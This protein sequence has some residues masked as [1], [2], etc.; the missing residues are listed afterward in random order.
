VNWRQVEG[1]LAWRFTRYLKHQDDCLTREMGAREAKQGLWS[2]P[3]PQA[4]WEVRATKQQPKQGCTLNM[5]S[6]M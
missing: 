5:A 3:N 4:P 1:G 2:E 6:A